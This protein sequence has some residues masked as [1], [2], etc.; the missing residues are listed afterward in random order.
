[1]LTWIE[2]FAASSLF[3]G[4]IVFGSGADWLE[5]SFLVGFLLHWR[6]TEWSSD[7]IRAFA[8]VSWF[9]QSIWFFAGL[10]SPGVRLFGL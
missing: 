8:V 6:A 9:F 7:G 3:W 4:W 2:L 1:M 5:G 10:F